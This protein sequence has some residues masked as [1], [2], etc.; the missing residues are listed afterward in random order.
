MARSSPSIEQQKQVNDCEANNVG[1]MH[2]ERTESFMCLQ[3]L[4]T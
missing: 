2:N 1:V 4:V 3:L